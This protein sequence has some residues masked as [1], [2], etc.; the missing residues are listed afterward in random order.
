MTDI[1]MTI[2]RDRERDELIIAI[3]DLFG[4]LRRMGEDAKA[5]ELK[6]INERR[7]VYGNDDLH[8]LLRRFGGIKY[9]DMILKTYRPNDLENFKKRG[10]PGKTALSE[11]ILRAWLDAQN[12]TVRRNM[13]S[14]SGE[15]EG[16]DESRYS[17][18]LL[19]AQVAVIIFD[20]VKQEF[21]CS[22]N[23]VSDLL[24][25]IAGSNEYN[26]IMDL[27][28]K[29][30]PWDGRDRLQEIYNILHIS[31]SDT[32]SR[33]L[34]RKWLMQCIALQN[35]S[36]REPFG[37][38]GALVL[39]G[40]Q[41]IGK[42]SFARKLALKPAFF[43]EGVSFSSFDRDA[44]I[45]STTAWIAELGE[46]GGTMRKSDRDAL[47][48]HITKA[49]DEY[50]VP[51]G[52]QSAKYVRRTSYIGTVNDEQFLVDPTGSRRWWV[53][54]TPDIDLES[55]DKLD[56]V[57]LWQQ[58]RFMVLSDVQGFRLTRDEQ[59]ALL[60][61]NTIYEKPAAG[62]EEL[63]DILEKSISFPQNFSWMFV[64]LSDFS[65]AHDSLRNT[66]RKV[67]G[68]A[69]K[70]LDREYHFERKSSI[71]QSQAAE[72][73]INSRERFIKLPM[74]KYLRNSV[75]AAL[76]ESADNEKIS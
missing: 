43:K 41:G 23:I 74:P 69:I 59:A 70:I 33:T 3:E 57:Q 9:S 66:S 28:D 22:Q 54:P 14:K 31:D 1:D 7:D 46:L 60:E 15:T 73:G 24:G 37:A 40:P 20:R 29:S 5:T 75:N 38:D 35:N 6:E 51:Y 48:N 42:T 32:L 21:S 68:A 63:R 61:R 36:S 47:K 18:E 67:L 27:L 25:V 39:Q 17:A 62:V 58:I 50:R 76:E 16:I 64:T 34:V 19:E 65:Q 55:L 71:P 56:V 45:Q 10:R 72:R 52:R 4:E 30:E 2:E 13:I 12:I 8:R 26:P 49:I 44:Y 53:V 11:D